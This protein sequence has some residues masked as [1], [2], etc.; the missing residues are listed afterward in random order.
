MIGAVKRCISCAH[1]PVSAALLLK[2]ASIATP[3]QLQTNQS[4]DVLNL[5]K[6]VST[7]PSLPG[8]EPMVDK[9]LDITCEY[10]SMDSRMRSVYDTLGIKPSSG[11]LLYGPSG[12][13]KTAVAHLLGRKASAHYKFLS[14]SCAELV[15]KVVGET[16]RKISQIFKS[17]YLLLIYLLQLYN[18]SLAIVTARLMAPCFLLLDN[19]D[20]I[21]GRSYLNNDD[22]NTNNSDDIM[23]KQPYDSLRASSVAFDRL[24]STLLVEIDGVGEIYE[25]NRV[26]STVFSNG[27]IYF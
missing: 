5:L 23:D 20:I 27:I 9:L 6:D 15:H 8:Y 11:L 4:S 21:L 18:Y 26:T 13:G 1:G 22:N 7:A 12:T 16:E 19:L 24:L 3:S 17:G 10:F 14:V 25:Y 2:E